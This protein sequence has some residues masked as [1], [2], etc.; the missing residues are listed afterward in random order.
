[1]PGRSADT[2]HSEALGQV[3]PAAEPDAAEPRDLPGELTAV[4]TPARRM[5]RGAHRCLMW[6]GS[7]AAALILVFG[8]GLWRLVQGPVE[9]GRLTPY[10]EEV[11]N[12]SADGYHVAIS[13]VRFAID[14]GSRQLELHIAGVRVSVGK[15]RAR[16]A[17]KRRGAAAR[18]VGSERREQHR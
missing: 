4:P 6:V 11:L 12:R 18:V 10:V 15:G 5:R 3:A 7:F 9:L 17:R 13:G 8:F 2:G 14:R 1:M 16:A